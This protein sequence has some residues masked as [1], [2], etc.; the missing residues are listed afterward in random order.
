MSPQSHRHR[1]TIRFARSALER[2]EQLGLPA[3]PQSFELWYVYATGQNPTLNKTIDAALAAPHGLSEFEFDQICNMHIATKHVANRLDS[4]AA[5]LS[6]EITQV[7]GMLG[8]A[9]VSSQNYSVQL[10]EGADNI[11][12]TKDISRLRPVVEALLESTKEKELETRTLQVNLEESKAKT[13]VLQEE[14]IALRAGQLKDRLT[15]IGNRQY[16]DDLST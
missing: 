2:I 1:Q 10:A 5:G 9:A 7:M 16:F 3:D 14:V 4:T 8:A 11:E 12:H 13:S 6:D 15:G